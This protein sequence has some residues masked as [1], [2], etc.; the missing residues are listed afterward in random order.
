MFIPSLG[1]AYLHMIQRQEQLC[2]PPPQLD[3]IKVFSLNCMG[4]EV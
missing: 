2:K 4:Y 1:S 3:L